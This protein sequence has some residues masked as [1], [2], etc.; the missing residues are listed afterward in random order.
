MVQEHTGLG[1]TD[2]G[3]LLLGMFRF[4]QCAAGRFEFVLL[5]G[6]KTNTSTIKTSISIWL[7]GGWFAILSVVN[8]E[9]H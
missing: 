8:I 7:E 9:S 5:F 6:G 3:S 4:G 1:Q 2:S